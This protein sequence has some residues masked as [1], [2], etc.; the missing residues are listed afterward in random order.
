MTVQTALLQG[1]HLL[2]DAAVAVPRLTAEVL[3]CHALHAERVYLFAHPE[4]ELRRTRMAA[5]RALSAR[6]SEGQ[7]DPIHHRAAGVLRARISREWRRAD[8]ASGNRTRGGNGPADGAWGAADRGY[9]DRVRR[10]GRDAATRDRRR[11]PGD[12]NLPAGGG[13]GCWKPPR[14]WERRWRWRSAI[15]W[16]RLPAA[17]WT[18]WF[19]IPLTCRWRSGRAC[20]TRCGI[21][22][23]KW[24][25]LA[26]RTGFAIYE[27]IVAEAPRVLRPGGW[28]IMELGFGCVERVQEMLAGWGSVHVEPD[29][30]GI[31]R[32]IAAQRG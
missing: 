24:R 26:A 6:A 14:V 20:S 1:T 25:Y 17:L 11:G 29:L 8:S 9:R 15:C 18:W 30:A 4:Q 7:A 2:E 21:G 12:R 32:V 16:R 23:R 31:P 13:Y 3:L 27:R 5:L 22:N 10:A 19:R 28:L